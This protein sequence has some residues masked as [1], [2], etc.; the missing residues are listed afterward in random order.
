MLN[1]VPQVQQ[2]NQN[3]TAVHMTASSLQPEVKTAM[4]IEL[5]G[6]NHFR[7]IEEPE[8]PN[9]TPAMN[10]REGGLGEDL[11]SDT[12]VI[13][14]ETQ[15]EDEVKVLNCGRGFGRLLTAIVAIT[16]VAMRN[17]CGVK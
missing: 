4:H 11:G 6:P 10:T 1:F 8:P 17:A 3:G 12:D 5:V 14:M 7:F 2:T 15:K 9:M 16:A 13:V